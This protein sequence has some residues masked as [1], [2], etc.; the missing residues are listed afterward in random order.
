MRRYVPI[1]FA[2]VFSASPAVAQSEAMLRKAFEGQAVV[3]RMDMPGTSTGVDVYPSREMPVDFRKVAGRIKQNGIGIRSGESQMIT[4]VKLLKDHVEVQL[5]GGGFGTFSDLVGQSDQDVQVTAQGKSAREYDLEKQIKG[6][7]DPG[8]R[9]QLDRELRDAR[10]ERER[11]NSQAAAN[12][13]VANRLADQ[14]ER[15]RRTAGGSRF[16]LRFKEFVPAEYQTPEGIRRAL[17]KYLTFPGDPVAESTPETSKQGV[18]SLHKGMS[19]EEVEAILG[20]AETASSKEA[21]GIAIQERTY[22]QGGQRVSARFANG[23]LV[24]FVIASN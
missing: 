22:V 6:E 2:L 24:D 21:A 14:E 9:K 17:A 1:V 13:A 5:G 20:P 3:L 11:N 7:A 18:S 23:V 12:A 16:N 4:K 19:L 8:R 10:H 15:E